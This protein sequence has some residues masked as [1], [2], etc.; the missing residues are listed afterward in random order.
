MADLTTRYMGLTLRNPIIVAS[1]GLTDSFEKI[2]EHDKNNA[3]AVVLKSLFEEQIILETEHKLSQAKSNHFLYAENSETLDYL[4][5]HL[6]DKE[7]SDYLAMIRKIKNELHIPVIASINCVSSMEWTGFA[8]QI[9]KAG[10][11]AIELNIFILPFNLEESQSCKGTEEKYYDIVRKVKKEISI[12]LA[13]KISPFFS[14]LGQV[15][16]NIEAEGADSVVLFNRFSRPNIDINT[17]KVSVAEA[18]STPAEMYNTLRWIALMANRTDMDLA[19]TKGI[20]D[21]E[22]VI[23]QILAGASVVQVSSA[24]YKKGHDYIKE[25]VRFMDSWMDSKGFNYIDQFK[26]RLS[27]EK[28]INPE[29]YERIQFMK[30][31]SEIK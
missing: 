27:Q 1:S 16:K 21:G 19:A 7:L 14:N 15:I 30:Y 29:V 10:A 18:F 31:F 2:K 3:G 25:M 22:S 17:M 26:G 4:D 12:P 8:K 20:H 9:E 24:L 23:K 5:V 6:K 13:V 11:D 28:S